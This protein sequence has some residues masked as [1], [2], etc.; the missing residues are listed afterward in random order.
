MVQSTQAAKSVTDFSYDT[1][2]D[3]AGLPASVAV[4]ADRPATRGQ[5]TEDQ[6]GA[7]FRA[8]EGGPVS[9]LLEGQIAV[10]GD[11]VLIDCP[12]VDAKTLA[13]LSRLDMRVARSGSQLIVSTSL[14][15]LDDVFAALDQSDPQLLVNPTRAD[16]IV[17]T[18]RVL[19][20]VSNARV[21]EM[22]EEDRLTL[23]RLSEQVDAIAQ[24]LEGL[25]NTPSPR[26]AG[27]PNAQSATG[28]AGEVDIVEGASSPTP[29]HSGIGCAR[30]PLPEPRL[31]R[32]II[33]NR[34]ARARFFDSELF[35][36]PAWDMLLDLT[37]AH[38]EHR[39]VSVTSLCIAAGVPA[40]TALRWVRQ[41][42]D[43]GIFVRI[44]DSTDKRRAF[45]ALSDTTAD[46]MA[47]YFAAIEVP[48]NLAA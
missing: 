36:D 9:A 16:R 42:V 23:L 33:A 5:I 34:Q 11:V 45:I 31:V 25:S 43:S 3:P 19:A 47:N 18:G 14:D 44:A 1:A 39:R 37:A 38:A 2:C 21:R 32:Q 41:M 6:V 4:F 8:M 13:A 15:A 30:A 40:T 10:L 29:L 22:S 46:A 35:S 17:A 20:Q 12:E 48:V 28:N 24:R 7:G 26:I 27:V